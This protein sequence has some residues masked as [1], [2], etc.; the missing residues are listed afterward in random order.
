MDSLRE[1]GLNAVAPTAAVSTLAVSPWGEVVDRHTTRGDVVALSR[2]DIIAATLRILAEGGLGL[3]SMRR[4]ADDLGVRVNTIYWHVANKQDL[5]AAAGE[6]LLASDDD[7]LA[8]DADPL[9]RARHEALRLR[10]RMLEVRDG[11]EVVALA[12]A[13]HAGKFAPTLRIADALRPAIGPRAEAAAEVVTMY[14]VGATIE[15]QNR[16][17]LERVGDG[18]GAE[19]D[20]D[21]AELLELGLGAILR[22]LV[23]A[24]SRRS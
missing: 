8:E 20:L 7:G 13:K 18:A 3:F 15:E 4:L 2:E 19:T 5:L 22:G 10:E 1:F 17:E 6:A 14:V 24:E 21:R 12:R 11:G 16:R 9:E 23:G